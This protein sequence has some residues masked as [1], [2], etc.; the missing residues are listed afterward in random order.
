MLVS[1]SLKIE[2]VNFNGVELIGIQNQAGNVFVGLKKVFENLGLDW[3]SQLA[4]IKK[5]PLYNSSMVIFT[6]DTESLGNREVVG[7]NI[8]YLP[9][10]LS[11]INV[12]KVNEESKKLLLE[13]QL[14][15]K[16]VLAA[17]FIKKENE[18]VKPK[19]GLELI[20][21]T[22]LEMVKI[23]KRTAIVEQK[24]DLLLEAKEKNLQEFRNV[25]APKV[26]PL[27]RTRRMELN[28][29]VRNYCELNQVAFQETWNEI[30][31]EFGM[32]SHMDVKQ[33]A[34]NK[35]IKP[36]DYLESIGKIEEIYSVAYEMLKGN[37][38]NVG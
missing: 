18:V 29:L 24:V 8:D 2:K 19:T 32:R 5:N 3:S 12:K 20:A 30:Y 11:T 34:K 17:A 15:A 23:E 9:I 36:L 10:L 35:K 37:F 26:L 1:Q 7:L 16:E 4:K 31:R 14:K 25:E 21:E 28:L 6:I 27:Q 38:E 22:A 33:R 13:F